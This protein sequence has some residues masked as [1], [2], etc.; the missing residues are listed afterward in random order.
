MKT[1][2]LT[3]SVVAAMLAVSVAY[4][5]P[6]AGGGASAGAARS[7]GAAIS[8][9]AAVSGNSAVSGNAGATTTGQPVSPRQVVPGPNLPVRTIPNPP[10][11]IISGTNRPLS[12]S[13]MDT[14]G[15]QETNE[16]AH[17]TNEFHRRVV[18]H[19]QA[20]TASDR[21]LLRTLRQTVKGA[22]G[23]EAESG[24]PVHFLIDNGTVTIVGTV[25]ND[26]ERAGLLANVQQTPG[27]LQVFNDL[28][29]GGAG[30]NANVPALRRGGNFLGAQQ[31]D[32]AFSSS[33]RA[34]LTAVQ[35]EAAGQLGINAASGGQM[36]VHFS[37]E[38]GVVGVTGRVNSP[39]EKAALLADIQRTPGVNRVVDNV[40]VTSGTAPNAI[41]PATQTPSVD[42]LFPTSRQEE[43]NRVLMNTTTNSS[44]D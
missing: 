23:M 15:F 12:N 26:A 1:I 39:Q 2:I 36:P 40:V 11:T 9:G 8:G 13:A 30:A 24:S 4:A 10:N 31:T 17:G 38:N 16:F 3:T 34:L 27:V 35:Q 5:A 28:H 18:D 22:L 25:Q 7:G 43:S 44:G 42:T 6:A 29:V 14:N 19:D 20:V 37:I 21:L 33:D 41:P 32:H